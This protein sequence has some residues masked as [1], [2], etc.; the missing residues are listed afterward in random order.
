MKGLSLEKAK[1]LLN[2]LLEEK[3]SI[4]GKFYKK[5]AEKFLEVLNQAE[6]NAKQKNMKN[7]FVKKIKA[8]KGEK[9]LRLKRKGIRSAKSVN[10][11]IT[12][13]EK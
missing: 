8:D 7:L 4:N 5:C 3:I 6:A 9:I 1:N 2:C 13:I 11:E 10:L 12:L